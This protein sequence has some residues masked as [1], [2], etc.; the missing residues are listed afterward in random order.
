MIR[1]FSFQLQGNGTERT[2]P[3]FLEPSF[4]VRWLLRQECP[5]DLPIVERWVR[6]CWRNPPRRPKEIPTSHRA[7]APGPNPARPANPRLV[8]RDARVFLRQSV[9]TPCLS[10]IRH[11]EGIWIEDLQGRRYMD[12]HGNNVHHIGYAHPRLLEAIRRQM[13]ELTFAPRRYTC[14]PA[15]ELAEKLVEITPAG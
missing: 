10:A 8:Q 3:V 7:A 14:M 9:S 15:V 2:V 11:A 6:P 12:F 1:R 4:R 5:A 13:D